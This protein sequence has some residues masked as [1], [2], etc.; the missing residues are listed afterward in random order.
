MLTPAQI[1]EKSSTTA[2]R[3]MTPERLQVL[4]DEAVVRIELFTARPYPEADK[5]LDM[6]LFRLVEALALTD[7]E[8]TLGAEAR[9]ITSE[10]DQG[11]SWSKET[12]SITTGSA[13]VDSLLRQWMTFTAETTEG[14]NVKARLL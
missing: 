1:V 14:G 3:D 7:N 4:L 2:V 12:A 13:I 6:A 9:G 11:Y 10:S 8:E 5:R